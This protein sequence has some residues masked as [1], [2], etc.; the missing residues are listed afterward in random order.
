MGRLKQLLPWHGSTVIAATFDA[1][2]PVCGA[3]MVVVLGASAGEVAAALGDREFDSVE[4]DPDAEQLVSARLG[5]SR[6]LERPATAHVLLHPADHPFVSV[7][8]LHALL[9][10]EGAA[11]Q[12]VIPTHEGRGGHPILLPRAVAADIF[13]WTAPPTGGLRAYWETHPNRVARI[14]VPGSASILHDLDTPEDYR[15]ARFEI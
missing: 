2:S 14:E 8:V 12:V 4:S 10:C 6:A 15:A 1:L 13:A 9:A 5:L 7:S 3:G 11:D